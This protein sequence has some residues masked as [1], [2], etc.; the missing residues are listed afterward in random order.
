MEDEQ[1]HERYDD[2]AGDVSIQI[3]TELDGESYER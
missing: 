1:A 3:A 2:D